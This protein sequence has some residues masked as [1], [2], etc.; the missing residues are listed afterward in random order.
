M[1]L[2]KLFPVAVVN[3]KKI[4]VDGRA[5]MLWLGKREADF[6]R[7]VEN[8]IQK[9][10]LVENVDYQVLRNSAE[11]PQGGRPRTDYVFHPDA[12]KD[13]A[14][15]SSSDKG[16]EVRDYFKQCEKVALGAADN[17]T[18]KINDSVSIMKKLT[19]VA[20]LF[21]L[22]GN[23]AIIS[24]NAATR[25]ITGIDLHQTLSIELVNDDQEVLLTPTDIGTEF[26]FSAQVIN[27]LLHDFGYQIKINDKYVPTKTG[28]AFSTLI[29]TG[30]K[31]SDGAMIQQLKWKHSIIEQLKA[32]GVG[33]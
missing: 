18:K 17:P 31:Y 13:I 23:A 30:K 3:S 33:N 14:M 11:N 25:K 27:R 16:K 1:E 24:A 29:D 21:G 26:G 12:A 32:N 15:M 10:Q 7:D 28:I 4:A 9:A 5:L 6:T 22:K 2:K 20:K 19:I 8:A